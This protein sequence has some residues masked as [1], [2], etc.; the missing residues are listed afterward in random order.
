MERKIEPHEPDVLVHWKTLGTRR[1]LGSAE[2][3]LLTAPMIARH[4]RSA[5]EKF[6]EHG[7]PMS[8]C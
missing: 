1:P 6:S 5:T 7:T 3:R 8:L 4:V 2:F